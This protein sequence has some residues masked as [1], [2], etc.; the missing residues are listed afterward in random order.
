MSR[1]QVAYCLPFAKAGSSILDGC[2]SNL[3]S[4]T[5]KS[6]QAIPV[7]HAL[8]WEEYFPHV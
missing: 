7:P 8:Y 1:S 2:L 3:F 4:D 5:P 6:L